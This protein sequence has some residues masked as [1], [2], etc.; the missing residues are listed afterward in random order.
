MKKG[1]KNG[2]CF[3][4]QIPKGNKKEREWIILR[5]SKE[6]SALGEHKDLV[7]RLHL[8]SERKMDC[9]WVKYY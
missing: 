3:Y 7:V 9:N 6:E 1:T 8:K 2:I 5:E 4:N